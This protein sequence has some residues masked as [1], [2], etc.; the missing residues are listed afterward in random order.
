MTNFK[1]DNNLEK[2]IKV[3]GQNLIDRAEDIGRDTKRV[4]TVTIYAYIT[5]DAILNFDVTK[6]YGVMF[7]EE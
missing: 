7:E 5:P 1:K 4:S 2:L 6:N 3:I